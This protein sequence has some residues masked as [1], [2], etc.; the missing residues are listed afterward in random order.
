MRFSPEAIENAAAL[1]VSDEPDA[2]F[3][4]TFSG[5]IEE[6]RAEGDHVAALVACRPWYWP[7]HL[8]RRWERIEIVPKPPPGLTEDVQAPGQ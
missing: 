6:L 4:I 5:T 2:V 3:T 1:L 7:F 8:R